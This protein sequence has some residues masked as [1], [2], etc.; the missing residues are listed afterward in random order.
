MP[1]FSNEIDTEIAAA[2]W[3][4]SPDTSSSAPTSNSAVRQPKEIQTRISTGLVSWYALCRLGYEFIQDGDTFVI[5]GVLGPIDL[6]EL[7]RYSERYQE[8][9]EQDQESRPSVQRPNERIT[10]GIEDGKLAHST[11]IAPCS[12]MPSSSHTHP[13]TPSDT[14]DSIMRGWVNQLLSSHTV[15]LDA[16]KKKPRGSQGG[17]RSSDTYNAWVNP[18][19]LLQDGEVATR[20]TTMW[21]AHSSHEHTGSQKAVLRCPPEQKG[22]VNIGRMRWLNMLN[23]EGKKP[24]LNTGT[25][26]RQVGRSIWASEQGVLD[27]TQDTEPVV[28]LS[29]PFFALPKMALE[30]GTGQKYTRTL[31]EFLYGF[32]TG[33]IQETSFSNPTSG[34]QLSNLSRILDIPEALFLMIGRGILISSSMLSR[35]QMMAGTITVDISSEIPDTWPVVY[36]ARITSPE[37]YI[38]IDEFC[39][40]WGKEFRQLVF[41]SSGNYGLDI[42][43]FR[44]VDEH[45]HSVDSTTW[46]GYLRSGEVER[47]SFKLVRIPGETSSRVPRDPGSEAFNG[48][49]NQNI[50]EKFDEESSDGGTFERTM[51]AAKQM[52]CRSR[53]EG[54]PVRNMTPVLPTLPSTPFTNPVKNHIPFFAWPLIHKTSNSSHADG[55]M[56]LTR[57]LEVIDQSL[58]EFGIT[59]DWRIFSTRHQVVYKC[60]V[61]RSVIEEGVYVRTQEAKDPL[62][63]PQLLGSNRNHINPGSEILAT[64]LK[65]SED[66]FDLFLPPDGWYLCPAIGVYWG[67]LHSIISPGDRSVLDDPCVGWVKWQP[68]IFEPKDN[69][70]SVASKLID[71]LT[72]VRERTNEIS[73]SVSGKETRVPGSLVSCYE[74]LTTLLYTTAK[75]L[76]VMNCERLQSIKR[77]NGHRILQGVASRV[78]THNVESKLK[79]QLEDARRDVMMASQTQ[80]DTDRLTISPIGLE[81]LLITL[82]RNLHGHPI[83]PETNQK[84]DVVRHCRDKSTALRFAAVRDPRRRRFLEISA[85]EEEMEALRIIFEVQTRT[86]KAYAQVLSPNFFPKGTTDRVDLGHR[87]DMYSLEKRHLDT[88]IQSLAEDGKTL[89]I[90]QRILA[91]TRHDMKQMIEV[92]DEG[93]GKAI[94]VFTFVT[95][96]FLPL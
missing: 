62:P 54:A 91:A 7:F 73:L 24:Q 66:I 44:L 17:Q 74:T 41:K 86:V 57:S 38:I 87:R 34:G 59:K 78:Q 15:H 77:S 27:G 23:T 46:L 72:D 71:T 43:D 31:L 85:L 76:S 60:R 81:F 90:L 33:G 65:L 3:G 92:L 93:H 4:Q 21:T 22:G 79:C 6:E 84:L 26:L 61:L 67:S 36:R 69:V 88:H 8:A 89:E 94:R 2:S 49:K 25:V 1:D 82:L 95:L 42:D 75:E 68:F 45:E 63:C 12:T 10:L 28:F 5:S 30:N 64:L 51:E 50:E 20:L 48:I 55:T 70:V 29:T 47:H 56:A 18:R 53:G 39:S 13:V 37:C 9:D 16:I 14:K 83:Y 96:F 40:Y 32:K 19:S 80:M 35:E 11:R 58:D 52:F